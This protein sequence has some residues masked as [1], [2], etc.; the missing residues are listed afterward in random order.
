MEKKLYI[1]SDNRGMDCTPENDYDPRYYDL[2]HEMYNEPEL[3]AEIING[4]EDKFGSDSYDLM[5]FDEVVYTE[6]YNVMKF[7]QDDYGISPTWFDVAGD[8]VSTVDELR[9][10]G[11][12]W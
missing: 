2:G 12:E 3:Y 5:S 8:D 7:L 10:D 6:N 4:V 9:A 11:W 1:N